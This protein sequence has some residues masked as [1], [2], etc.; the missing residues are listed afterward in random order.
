M[1][2]ADKKI[3]KYQQ[4]LTKERERDKQ[5]RELNKIKERE[6]E[7]ILAE[8]CKNVLERVRKH[9]KKLKTNSCSTSANISHIGSYKC[10]QSFGKAVNRL[11]KNLP[12]S[13]SKT[14]AIVKKLALDVGLSLKEGNK[15]QTKARRVLPEHHKKCIIDFYCS[16][17]ISRQAPGKNDVK[18][19]KCPQ[20]GK[21]VYMQ[22]RHLIMTVKEAFQEFLS[23]YSDIKVKKSL[24]FSLRPKHVLP[25]SQMPHNV[26]VCKYHSNVNFLLKSISK[27]EAAFPRNHK[28]LLEYICCNISNESCMLNKC[29]TCSKRQASDLIVDFVEEKAIS[30]KKWVEEGGICLIVSTGSLKEALNK[31]ESKMLHFKYHCYVKKIQEDYFE[32]SKNNIDKELGSDPYAVVQIDFA[33][34]YSLTFQDEIQSA[35]WSHQQVGIFTCCVWLPNKVTKSYTVV[36]ND[37]SHSKFCVWAFLT[38]IVQDINE[39]F[40][41]IEKLVIFSD[42]CAA[43][44]K[45]KYSVSALCK[46]EADF[47]VAIE[48]N[49]FASSH[50]K[51]AVDGIGGTVKRHAWMAVKGNRNIHIE[52]A[53]DFH[54]HIVNKV[55]GVKSLYVDKS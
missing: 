8:K 14:S 53:R 41:F 52:S 40:S 21:R 12:D 39:H 20:T 38:K 2:P 48:W 33:E 55:H 35:H 45:S 47:K 18:S 26:C 13:P 27:V 43:Q 7:E 51:G 4:H 23:K 49:F 29:L 46:I 17:T 3:D 16:D 1:A 28:E 22:I 9:R 25:V 42:S 44:F 32:A 15:V 31:L 50:G 30:W 36:S 24:F 5:R 11:K 54:N 37:T 10:R 19:I 6:N 34:N